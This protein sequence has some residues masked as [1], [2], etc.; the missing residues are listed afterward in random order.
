MKRKTKTKTKTIAGLIVV[1]AIVAVAMLA[2]CVEEERMS[3]VEIKEMALATAES[4]DTYTF[5]M[6][7]TQKI[8]ISNETGE[9]EMTKL[10]T[11]NGV[12]D[13][14]NKKMNQ[15]ITTTM[16]MPSETKEMKMD[17]YFINNTMY[18]KREGIPKMPA[19]WRKMEMPEV[20]KE[21]WES[22]NQV[23]Q[24]MELLNVSKVEQLEDEKVNDVDCYVLKLTPDIEKHWETVMKQARLSE[25]MQRLQQNDSFDIGKMIKEMSIKQWIAKD[26]KFP[27]KTEMQLKIVMSSEDLKL[28]DETKEKFTMTMDQRTSIVFHDYNEPVTIELPKEAE[29]AAEFPMMPK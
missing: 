10:I 25:L 1:I 23:E 2:G 6:D 13:N 26:T 16:K 19:Q 28:R 12:V 20:Y 21:F 18:T 17:M 4:I 14:I 24:Q 22:Q 27:M 15:E 7:M 5:D 9:T 3:T 11:G 8:L 29:S